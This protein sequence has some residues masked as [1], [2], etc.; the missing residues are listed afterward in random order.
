MAPEIILN[1]SSDIHY[2]SKC[3]LWSIG[4][5]YYE[6]LFGKR[7]LFA[8]KN[9]NKNWDIQKVALVIKNFNNKIE[10]FPRPISKLS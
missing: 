2:N 10:I 6:M 7:F 3:D 4:C 5:V 8:E 1:L 9:N